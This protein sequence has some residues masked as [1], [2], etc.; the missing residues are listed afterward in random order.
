MSW[1]KLDP[2]RLLMELTAAPTAEA[3]QE[4]TM[5]IARSLILGQTGA[6]EWA[7]EMLAETERTREQAAAAGRASAAKRSARRQQVFNGR[8]T[9]VERALKSVEQYIPTDRQTDK[10]SVDPD[11]DSPSPVAGRVGSGS[12]RGKPSEEQPDGAGAGGERW[13]ALARQGESTGEMIAGC[14]DG[15]LPGLACWLCMEEKNGLARKVYRA[16]IRRAGVGAFRQALAEF[17]SEVAQ[18][19]GEPE[20]RGRAFMARVRR[21][22]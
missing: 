4:R 13:T 16:A 1:F 10:Q 5:K 14:P 12:D 19:G 9:G 21:L 17:A 11:P 6:D 15:E 3:W 8:S 22:K 18:P 7:D 20:S 2:A